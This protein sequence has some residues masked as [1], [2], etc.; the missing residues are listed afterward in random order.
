MKKKKKKKKAECT[1]LDSARRQEQCGLWAWPGV[2]LYLAAMKLSQNSVV[3]ITAA[4]LSNG[5]KSKTVSSSEVIY[6]KRRCVRKPR[7]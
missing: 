6:S 2:S 4:C 1:A 3:W 7:E 5:V